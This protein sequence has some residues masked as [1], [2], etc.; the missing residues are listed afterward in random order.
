MVTGIRVSAAQ[1]NPIVTAIIRGGITP[2]WDDVVGG[3]LSQL[4]AVVEVEGFL[5]GFGVVERR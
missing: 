4:L 5:D 3:E 2:P 1:V